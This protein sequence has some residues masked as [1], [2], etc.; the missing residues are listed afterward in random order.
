M[1]IWLWVNLALFVIGGLHQG[2]CS[3]F[4]PNIIDGIRRYR[5]GLEPDFYWVGNTLRRATDVPGPAIAPARRFPA[6]CD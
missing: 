2:L 1:T 4:G 6:A 5:R 3:R